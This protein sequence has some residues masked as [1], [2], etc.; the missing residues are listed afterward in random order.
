MPPKYSHVKRRGSAPPTT[1]SSSK[2]PTTKQDNRKPS[3]HTDRNISQAMTAVAQLE[4]AI[5]RILLIRYEQDM[6]R[7]FSTHLYSVALCHLPSLVMRCTALG[8]PGW[9]AANADGEEIKEF[10]RS[11]IAMDLREAG[12]RVA[13]KSVLWSY[14]ALR[15]FAMSND[16]PICQKKGLHSLRL[17][18]HFTALKAHLDSLEAMPAVSFAKPPHLGPL[19]EGYAVLEDACNLAFGVSTKG[20]GSS[21]G[22][23][24]DQDERRL[25]VRVGYERLTQ[26]LWR[27]ARE[28]DVRGYGSILR[29]KLT[30]KWCDCGCSTDHLSEVCERTVRDGEE[31][32][33]LR[34]G[35]GREWDGRGVGV[36]GWETHEE[37]DVW[38]V[39]LDFASFDPESRAS[40]ND[41][42]IGEL[43][44][45]K[46]LQAEREK[47]LGNA[48]FR[49]GDY[50]SA[51]QHYRLAHEIEP[52][53]PRYQLNLAAAYIKLND[54]MSTEQACNAALLQ[55]MSSKGYWRRAK[56]RKMLGR[57]D[58]AI[59]DLRALIRLQPYNPEAISEL[60]ALLPPN[61]SSAQPTKGGMV[62]GSSSSANDDYLDLPKPRLPKS[63]P[64]ETT[65][66]DRQKLK[67]SNLPLT[68][69]V[70][71]NFEFMAA[72]GTG[73]KSPSSGRN[74]KP[75]RSGSRGGN[76]IP[77]GPDTK[78]NAGKGQT[79]SFTYPNW[80]R[81]LV[82]KATD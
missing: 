68:V 59:K 80:E 67:I 82:K 2:K 42:T 53:L 39:E 14:T 60:T 23:K 62:G 61:P 43:M 56:A 24:E 57:V 19:T 35:K 20:K 54:W 5:S 55:H 27:V 73:D 31:T 66:E 47:E 52:E 17:L 40:E 7:L 1:T 37:E 63:L 18:P 38:D 15:Q 48:S 21:R 9:V 8:G 65:D 76:D 78:K 49:T 4:R 36:Y 10:F 46:Y 45:W 6:A 44:A 16:V 71:S 28:F 11:V 69:D 33:G 41:M 58:E 70:P 26:T 79:M 32:A 30:N 3:P 77:T 75:K 74:G 25:K 64:F 50:N 22:S 72:T 51:I 13:T 34:A 12:E 29:E 81:Y